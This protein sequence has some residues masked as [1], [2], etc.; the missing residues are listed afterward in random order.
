MNQYPT[1][2]EKIT[3]RIGRERRGP[4]AAD[5]DEGR[6]TKGRPSHEPLTR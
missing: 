6:V 4:R 3:N 2:R 1:F 5:I